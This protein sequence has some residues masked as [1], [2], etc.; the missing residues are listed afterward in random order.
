MVVL[1]I[2]TS[3]FDLALGV[4]LLLMS[5]FGVVLIDLNYT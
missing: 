1:N 3:L 4:I 2:L 5:F